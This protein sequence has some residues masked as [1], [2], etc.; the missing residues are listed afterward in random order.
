MLPYPDNPEERGNKVIDPHHDA[1]SLPAR[2]RVPYRHQGEWGA[3]EGTLD[4]SSI[5]N[6]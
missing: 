5:P 6:D 1:E 4:H 3:C 2:Y